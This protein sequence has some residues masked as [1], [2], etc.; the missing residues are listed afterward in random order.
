MKPWKKY[1]GANFL[2][3]TGYVGRTSLPKVKTKFLFIF[4]LFLSSIGQ[5]SGFKSKMAIQTL[6]KGMH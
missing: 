5:G 6:C 4:I 1:I 3:K 2:E